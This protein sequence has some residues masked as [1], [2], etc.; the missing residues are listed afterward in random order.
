[1]VQWHLEKAVVVYLNA[2]QQGFPITLD[3]TGTK[4]ATYFQN[5]YLL[6]WQTAIAKIYIPLRCKHRINRTI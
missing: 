4:A 1:M 3:R 2:P 6:H 5:G